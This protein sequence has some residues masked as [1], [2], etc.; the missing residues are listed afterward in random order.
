MGLIL[1]VLEIVQSLE[2][3]GRTKRFCDTVIGLKNRKISVSVICFAQ[4]SFWVQLPEV[5]VFEKQAG[6]DWTLIGKIRQYIKA[7]NINIVHAHCELSQLYSGIAA[8]GTS[9]KVIGTF[10]RSDPS[11][12]TKNTINRLIKIL[13]HEYIAV[14][15]NRLSLLT[16]SLNFSKKHCHVVHAGTHL[17]QVEADKEIIKQQLGIAKE[18][19]VLVSIGHLG[20]IKGH[21]DT[22]LALAILV[23]KHPNL[24]LYILGDGLDIEKKELN[25][26]VSSNSLNHHVTFLGQTNDVSSWLDACDIFVQPSIEEAF[27]LVFIEAWAHKKPVVATNVGG[28]KEIIIENETGLLVPPKSPLELAKAISSIIKS[29]ELNKKLS[30]LGYNRIKNNFS[31]S[32]MID[33]YLLIFDQ[34]DI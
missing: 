24:H 23:E 33:N 28:I 1:N 18:Q 10:H 9:T 27:G 16:E 32:H 22:I 3:G 7:N 31:I 2:K 17:P 14:S 29:P 21:Q 5:I 11:K 19:Y 12:Y 8:I 13:L 30:E 20:Q 4:P 34:L 26:L 6:L 15:N 25:D